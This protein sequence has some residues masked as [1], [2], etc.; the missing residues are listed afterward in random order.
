MLLQFHERFL[1]L[2]WHFAKLNGLWP[3]SDFT[4]SCLSLWSCAQ[5]WAVPSPWPC[6]VPAC[7]LEP[8][9]VTTE[10]VSPQ[11]GLL[12]QVVGAVPHPVGPLVQRMDKNSVGNTPELAAP[13]V[14]SHAFTIEA[15]LYGSRGMD[16]L[17]MDVSASKGTADA[18][19]SSSW[20]SPW[21]VSACP[22]S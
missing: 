21:E 19:T 15:F 20:D 7:A 8:W 4:D 6:W 1:K 5:L 17:L 12:V 10:A 18:A 14:R 2:R 9:R 22:L 11:P 13:L 16:S 3:V